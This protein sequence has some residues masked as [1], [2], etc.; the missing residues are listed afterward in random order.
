ME[1]ILSPFCESLTGTLS[2]RH[3]VFIKQINNRFY[4]FVRKT[5]KTDPDGLWQFVVCCV[6]M[7]AGPFLSDVIA[8]PLELER[9][10]REAGKISL[11]VHLEPKQYHAKDIVEL[12]KQYDV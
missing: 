8:D 10:L 12:I 5:P 1:L 3:G 2:K 6:N 4:A 11:Q 7:C 9:A